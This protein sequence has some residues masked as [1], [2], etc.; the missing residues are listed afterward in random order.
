MKK[1]FL[2]EGNLGLYKRSKSCW[3]AKEKEIFIQRPLKP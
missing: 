1:G 2:S 3:N